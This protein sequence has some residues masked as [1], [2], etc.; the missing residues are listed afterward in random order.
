MSPNASVLHA[1]MPSPRPMHPTRRV[2]T[3]GLAASLASLGE[4]PA[5]ASSG[6]PPAL[7]QDSDWRVLEAAPARLRLRPEPAPET[8]V[9]AFDGAL[10]GPVVR[11]RHGDE[12]RVRLV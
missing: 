7:K 9:W 6:A 4:G 3:L 10:P 5:A 12:L 8:E 1:F 2:V 11:I